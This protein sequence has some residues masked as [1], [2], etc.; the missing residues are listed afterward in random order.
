[1]AIIVREIN[2]V[3]LTARIVF[4]YKITKWICVHEETA[5]FVRIPPCLFGIL[6]TLRAKKLP[7]ISSSCDIAVQ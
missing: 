5:C 6:L 7:R 2:F 4:F 3:H 1:M